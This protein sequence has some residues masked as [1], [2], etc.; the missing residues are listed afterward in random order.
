MQIRSSIRLWRRYLDFVW[1]F[2]EIPPRA[3]SIARAAILRDNRDRGLRFLPIYMRR[4]ARL[5]I[6]SGLG[7]AASDAMAVPIAAGA[8]FTLST[9]ASIALL[10]A[11]IGFAGMRFGAFDHRR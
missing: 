10:V 5:L 4:Y 7:G 3:D 11:V 8:C 2:H 6:G 9:V 1:L